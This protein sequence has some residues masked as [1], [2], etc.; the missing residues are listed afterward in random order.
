MNYSGY[1]A[2][3]MLYDVCG[4]LTPINRKYERGYDTLRLFVERFVFHFGSYM[5][6][7]L[8]RTKNALIDQ[9]NDL[10]GLYI[11]IFERFDDPH[12]LIALKSLFVAS[13]L[14]MET[15]KDSPAY[16]SNISFYFEVL[17]QRLGGW[18]VLDSACDTD[19]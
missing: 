1:V 13:Y 9:R 7:K 6:P 5:I 10:M 2:R 19:I 8:P 12:S 17:T 16:C 18:N 15:Y 11:G 14:M 4:I 3:R